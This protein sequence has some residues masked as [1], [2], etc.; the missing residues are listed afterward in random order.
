LDLA[1]QAPSATLVCESHAAVTQIEA[2]RTAL[3]Q[4]FGL[5]TDL[6]A[7]TRD[8]VFQPEHLRHAPYSRA[9]ADL[10]RQIHPEAFALY[11]ELQARAA[12]PST[13]PPDTASPALGALCEFAAQLPAPASEADRRALLTMLVALTDPELYETFARGH[14][15][16]THELEAQRRAWEETA[17]ERA[18]LLREQT[19]WAEP[20]M[21]DLEKLEASP[22]VR[23][24]R[25]FGLVTPTDK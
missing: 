7:Q 10:L 22:L 2:F 11:G 8:A 14:A 20:R 23:A 12:L 3:A 6:T 21:R 24:L 19:A 16:R 25:R 9:A 15:T 4:S 13:R 5:V 18:E 17:Q 1:R